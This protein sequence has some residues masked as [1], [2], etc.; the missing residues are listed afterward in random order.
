MIIGIDASRAT[1]SFQRGSDQYSFY[2][3]QNLAQIDT[4]NEYWLYSPHPPGPELAQLPQNF[5]WKILP[6]FRL[7]TQVRLSYEMFRHPPDLLFVPSHVL[8][9]IHPQKTVVTVHD[10]ASRYFPSAYSVLDHFY[11]YLALKLAQKASKIIVPSQATKN[12]LLKWTKIN[13]KKIVVIHHGVD[14]EIYQSPQ[15][16][17]IT[18][19]YLLFLGKLEE[20]KNVKRIIEAF[21]ILKQEKKIPHKLIL[22]GQPGFHYQKIKEKI[23]TLPQSIQKEIIQTGYLPTQEV[24]CWLKN[25]DILL[26]PTLYE[27]FGLPILEAMAAKVPVLTSQIPVAKEVAS[28][29]A[30]F[31]NPQKTQEIAMGIERLISDQDLRRRLIEKGQKRAKLFS[32]QRCA[33]KTLSVLQEVFQ[34]KGS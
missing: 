19:P 10:L 31:I 3:I 26:Y 9:W 18:Y 14:Y 27:G 25:A 5:R 29:A 4:Q 1:K 17:K 12:D 21:A 24:I 33:Q 32:W 6:F 13:P 30:F 15:K 16:K 22:I 7:W 11:G 8:P 2:L 28:D 23:K 34:E 20:R